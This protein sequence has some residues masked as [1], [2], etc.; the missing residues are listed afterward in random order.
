MRKVGFQRTDTVLFI[1]H[2]GEENKLKTLS[3]GQAASA[4]Q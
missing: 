3:M 2:M 1:P 4:N